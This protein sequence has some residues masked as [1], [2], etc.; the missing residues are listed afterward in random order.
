MQ[1]SR[2]SVNMGL[3]LAVFDIPTAFA[4][5]QNYPNPFDRG[6]VIPF[7]LPEKSQVHIEVF[8]MLGRVV[9]KIADQTFE[10]ARKSVS[11]FPATSSGVYFVTLN[12]TSPESSNVR[13]GP[14]KMILV[15]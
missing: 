9:A 13:N 6:T 4:L 11:W 10:R 8:D 1:R 2:I 12:A 5:R 15:K 7:D 3:T 14:G